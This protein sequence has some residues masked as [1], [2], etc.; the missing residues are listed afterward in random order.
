MDVMRKASDLSKE[1]ESLKRAHQTEINSL[2]EEKIG[3]EQSLSRYH[4]SDSPESNGPSRLKWLVG[5]VLVGVIG[6]FL[7]LLILN[8]Q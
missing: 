6:S 2:H 7:L 8:K 5:G 4:E 3:L 1:L